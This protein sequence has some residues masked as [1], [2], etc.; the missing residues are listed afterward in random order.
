MREQGRVQAAIDILDEWLA[1]SEPAERLLAGWGRRHR[2]AGS[3]DRRAIGDLVYDALRK[4]RSAQWISGAATETGRSLIL[5]TIGESGRDPGELFDG[6]Q[7][8]PAPLTAD[9][10]AT[11]R[12]L[13]EAPFVIRFDIPDFLEPHMRDLDAASLVP[14]RARAP[15]D[16]R[17]NRLK[18]D[19]E[20]ATGVLASAGIEASGAALD[21]DCLRL[22][23]GAHKVGGS[24]AY[25]DGLVEIQDAASQAAAR[26]AGA[27][28]GERVL[29]FCAGGGG[30]SLAFAAHMAGEGEILAHDVSSARLDQI[31][32]RAGRAGARITLVEPGTCARLAGSC[33]LVFVD[34]PCSGSGGWRRNPEAKWRL[35]EDGLSRLTELQTSVLGEASCAVAPGGRLVYATCSLL[36]VEN[37]QIL[38]RFLDAKVGF[39]LEEMVRWTDLHEGDG[40][41]C[42]R[43]RKV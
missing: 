10:R 27:S 12:E 37:M 25:R 11:L 38:R 39:E 34:A 5:G 31:P 13:A 4:R 2:F 42:A 16:L 36:D 43:L 30:K 6:S 35:T 14:S 29:D 21:P 8:G 18:T 24:D 20:T 19:V 22:G 41:F 7:H 28:P 3:G 33:D 23:R 40:F 9:E 32:P 17:V 26:F 1:G 15:L